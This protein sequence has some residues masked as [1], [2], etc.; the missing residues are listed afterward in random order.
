MC[1][2]AAVTKDAIDVL[3]I[4]VEYKVEVA[5]PELGSAPIPQLCILSCRKVGASSPDPADEP[6]ALSCQRLSTRSCVD[7]YA[8][9]SERIP[10]TVYHKRMRV[11]RC[12]IKSLPTEFG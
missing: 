10:V 2:P 11:A 5:N 6:L 8:V 12:C 7:H 4:A 9:G 1:K 3:T